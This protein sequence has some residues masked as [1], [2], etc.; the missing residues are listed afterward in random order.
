M[1]LSRSGLAVAASLVAAL[2][3]APAYAGLLGSTVTTGEYYPGSATVCSFCP[4]PTTTTVTGGPVY[5]NAF[6]G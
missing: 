3:A 2:C 5:N 4:A 6:D 1:N